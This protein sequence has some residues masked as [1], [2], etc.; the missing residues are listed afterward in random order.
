MTESL[1]RI[2]VPV[3]FSAHSEKAIRYAT[4]LANKFGARLSLVH[5]IEDPFVT[6]AW[7]AEVFV[8][9]I[10]ELLNDLIKSAKTQLAER[11]KDLAAHGFIIETAVITGRPATAIVEQASTGRFD[12]IVMGTHGRTGLSHALL[13]SVAERVVQKAPCPVLTVRDAAPAAA[14]VRFA[15]TAAAV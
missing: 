14:N 7:Q 15:A 1:N 3:D 11:K 8:P 5:V 4:T 12:L 9:N 2:L 6:G 10:P 13:G